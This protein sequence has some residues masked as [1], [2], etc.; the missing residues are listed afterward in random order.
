MDFCYDH[1]GWTGDFEY[2]AEKQTRNESKSTPR[3]NRASRNL[4]STPS[5][6]PMQ[7]L[8]T[9]Q[10][11]INRSNNQP[12]NGRP[13]KKV[14]TTA[15]NTVANEHKPIQESN[16]KEN[17]PI[18]AEKLSQEATQYGTALDELNRCKELL[19]VS[20][21]SKESWMLSDSNNK[22]NEQ[23]EAIQSFI[24]TAIEKYGDNGSLYLC[25]KPGTGKVRWYV[26]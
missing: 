15:V 24:C 14:G 25:G 7:E 5:R 23:I 18:M 9:P 2:H 8:K 6:V 11:C 21:L 16:N 19:H 12:Y 26:T 4:V 22:Q 13:E 10:E 17:N 3:S 1:L 20:S